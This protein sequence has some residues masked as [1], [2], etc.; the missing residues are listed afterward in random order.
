MLV[1]ENARFKSKIVIYIYTSSSTVFCLE[2]SN[3]TWSYSLLFWTES[4]LKY[5]IYEE[6]STVSQIERAESIWLAKNYTSVQHTIC[7]PT[8]CVLL[9]RPI[10]SQCHRDMQVP[11]FWASGFQGS[12]CDTN[13]FVIPRLNLLNFHIV[14]TPTYLYCYC[15]FISTGNVP[16]ISFRSYSN[17]GIIFAQSTSICEL[18]QCRTSG[19]KRSFVFYILVMTKLQSAVTEWFRLLFMLWTAKIARKTTLNWKHETRTQS[20]LHGAWEDCWLQ[21]KFCSVARQQQ[22]SSYK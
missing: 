22:L 19:L 15:R 16:K 3:H 7:S 1:L 10:S 17:H 18:L 11:R 9:S 6:T 5:L 4:S 20:F 12:Q 8:H 21:P 14:I 2:T 13:W